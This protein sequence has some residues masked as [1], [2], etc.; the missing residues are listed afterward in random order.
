MAQLPER[1]Y[2]KVTRGG[3]S[4][5]VPVEDLSYYKRAGYLEEGEKLDETNMTP[6]EKRMA[7][8]A[9]G[10]QP[11]NQASSVNLANVDVPASASEIAATIAYGSP[12][13]PNVPGPAASAE[14]QE[15]AEEDAPKKKKV[16]R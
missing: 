12:G 9:R 15:D 8:I 6:A 7:Q 14:A 11:T 2:V 1:K 13:G 10:E 5:T 4:H 16:G 3:V